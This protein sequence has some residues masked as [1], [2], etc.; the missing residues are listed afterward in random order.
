MV[1][2]DTVTNENIQL[3]SKDTGE[4]QTIPR[5]YPDTYTATGRAKGPSQKDLGRIQTNFRHDTGNLRNL[6]L[7]MRNGGLQTPCTFL[8][9][10]ARRHASSAS[11]VPSESENCTASH[12]GNTSAVPARLYRPH[13]WVYARGCSNESCCPEPT[14]KRKLLLY[15][16]LIAIIR[17]LACLRDV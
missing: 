3:V 9:G 13:S 1:K 8:I 17:M 10:V 14:E 16:C 12:F 5:L 7:C 15:I 11:L 6:W 2:C 4:L